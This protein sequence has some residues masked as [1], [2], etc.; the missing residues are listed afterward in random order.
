MES[1]LVVDCMYLFTVLHRVDLFLFCSIVFFIINESHFF[2]LFF[3]LSLIRHTCMGRVCYV[4]L[5]TDVSDGSKTDVKRIM[6]CCRRLT[7]V[8]FGVLLIMPLFRLRKTSRYTTVG[9]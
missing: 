7:S 2:L 6:N 3:N 1:T 5:C 9:L 8:A 4:S